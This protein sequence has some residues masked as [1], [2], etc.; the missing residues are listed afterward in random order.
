MIIKSNI[1]VSAQIHETKLY[2]KRKFLT[3]SDDIK[4]ANLY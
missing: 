3:K 2:N 1:K 4:L